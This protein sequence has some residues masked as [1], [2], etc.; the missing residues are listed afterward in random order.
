CD[1]EFLATNVAASAEQ[2]GIHLDF[3]QLGKPAQ[4][5]FIERFNQ[6]YSTEVLDATLFRSLVEV[7]AIT[8]WL[9]RYNTE[10]GL[11]PPLSFLRRPTSTVES[12]L[13]TV[14]LTGELPARG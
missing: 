9:V 1:P 6:T 13:C 11:V 2:R 3:I 4:N 7:R 10:L 14:C 12:P 8:D 5:A